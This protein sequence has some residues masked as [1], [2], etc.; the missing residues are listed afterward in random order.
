[1]ALF[2]TMEPRDRLQA[3]AEPIM[4]IEPGMMPKDTDLVGVMES[5][6]T[7]VQAVIGYNAHYGQQ[8]SMHVASNGQ[9][10]WLT[11]S[12]LRAIFGYAFEFKGV[13]RVNAVV[14]VNN[15]DI[16]ILCLKLGFRIEGTMACGADDGSDGILFA[17]LAKDCRW[18]T[19]A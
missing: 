1:M 19:E 11:R 13:K 15:L 8:I 12:I 16:Q 4:G 10:R 17:M 6:T 7:E 3:W 14:S 2:L 5:D 9:K 18:I